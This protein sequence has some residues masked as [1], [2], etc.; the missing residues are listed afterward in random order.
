MNCVSAGNQLHED[1]GEEGPE[2]VPDG[3]VDRLQ[4][5][6]RC[7]GD[8]YSVEEELV[9]HLDISAGK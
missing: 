3:E 2:A 1:E 7:H 8:S 9:H 6:R 5:Y 4:R